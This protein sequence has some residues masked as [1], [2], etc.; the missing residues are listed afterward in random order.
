MLLNVWPTPS[1]ATFT[2]ANPYRKHDNYSK[3]Q[4]TPRNLYKPDGILPST[5]RP[6]SPLVGAPISTSQVGVSQVLVDIIHP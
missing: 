1:L 4:F 2:I 5:P 3:T 6:N